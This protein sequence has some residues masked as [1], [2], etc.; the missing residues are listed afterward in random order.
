MSTILL[1]EPQK[2]QIRRLI[3][4]LRLAGHECT[5]AHTAD[6]TVNWLRADKFLETRFDLL[7]LGSD[8]EPSI[9]DLLLAEVQEPGGMPV[10]CLYRHAGEQPPT[11]PDGIVGCRPED[12]I[13][14]LDECL[15]ETETFRSRTLS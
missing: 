4:L 10:V 9:L 5:V 13:S 15:I 2:D 3:F 8:P 12:L 6:E 1:Y 7:L 14:T 11:L